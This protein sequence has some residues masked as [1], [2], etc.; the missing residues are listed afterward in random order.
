MKSRRV[1]G[2]VDSTMNYLGAWETSAAVASVDF[3]L[4]ILQIC[5]GPMSTLRYSTVL[6]I[7]TT[8]LM[9]S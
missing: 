8:A 6:L 5:Q 7:S 1:R 4:Q 9:L 3:S 2:E